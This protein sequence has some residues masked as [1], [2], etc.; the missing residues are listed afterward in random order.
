MLKFKSSIIPRA[1]NQVFSTIDHIYPTRSSDNSFKM[2][3]FNLKLTRFSVGF[4]GLAI[5]NTFLTESEKSYTSIA[6]FKSKIKAIILNLSNKF[7]LFEIHITSNCY[8]M[9]RNVLFIFVVKLIIIN[10][11]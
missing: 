4:R 9:N 2:H 1:F 11:M 10:I 3:D 7:L 6:V 5:W 8:Y